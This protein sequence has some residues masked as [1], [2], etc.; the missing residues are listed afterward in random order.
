[1]TDKLKEII[2]SVKKAGEAILRIYEKPK[3]IYK[4]EDNSVVTEADLIAEKIVSSA[5]KS[6][7]YPILSEE[8]K[9]DLTRLKKEKVWILDPLDGTLDF[10][11]KTGEFSIMLGLVSKG[12]PILA[13]VYKPSGD[14]LYFAERGRGAYMEESG[15]PAKKLKV[16]S[17]DGFS[18]ARILFSRNHLGEVEKKFINQQ[19]MREVRYMGSFGVKLGLIAEGKAEG[20]FNPSSKTSEWD[21]CAPGLILSESGGRLTGMRGEEFIYNKKETKNLHGV[22]ASNSLL[23]EKII[24]GA[25]NI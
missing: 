18:D 11:Q 7:G 3:G 5:L 16:S 13:V 23:H 21:V 24:E 12:E 15:K 22:V 20:H 6:F 14:K 1:M 25:K 8:S 2:K 4:K 10:L 19:K 17:V 9:D